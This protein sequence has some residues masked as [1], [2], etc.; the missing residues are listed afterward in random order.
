MS[1][2]LELSSCPNFAVY[3]TSELVTTKYVISV[4]YL[5]LLL[6]YM[7]MQINHPKSSDLDS[8]SIYFVKIHEDSLSITGDLYIP[9]HTAQL[10]KLAQTA[11]NYTV[12]FMT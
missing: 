4:E 10:C 8:D 1:D 9:M 2:K 3:I 12:I 7:N 5:G 6:T 11:A